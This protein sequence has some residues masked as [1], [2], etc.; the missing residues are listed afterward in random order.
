[1]RILGGLRAEGVEPVIVFWALG[2]ELR[3]LAS[4]SDAVRQR[5]DLGSAMQKARV[6][7]N[8][9]GLVRSCVSRAPAGMF[10]RLL[11]AVGDG[12]AAA[13]GQLRADPWQ[14]ASNVVLG[15][16]FAGKEAA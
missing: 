4:L 6:W 16:A 10:H 9:Q 13:K 12:D 15:L 5:I 3:M 2:R 11:K 8:R 1:M 14:L 7:R